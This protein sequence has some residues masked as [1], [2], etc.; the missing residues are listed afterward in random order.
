MGLEWISTHE[1][2][3]KDRSSITYGIMF[4]DSAQIVGA[5]GLVSNSREEAELGYWIGKDYWGNG[6]CTEVAEK[7]LDFGF[8]E[9]GLEQLLP[10]IWQIIHHQVGFC[11]L[12]TSPSPR[13]S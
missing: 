11:L 9:L 5:M 1:Q 8:R 13:D 10:G 4:C 3:W 6:Y 7:L 2:G 12:Y